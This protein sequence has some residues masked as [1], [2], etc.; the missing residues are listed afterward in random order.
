[1]LDNPDEIYHLDVAENYK[2]LLY[3]VGALAYD[4]YNDGMWI[5]TNDGLFFYDFQTRTLLLPFKGCLEV[6]D[7]S[8][9][10]VISADDIYVPGT[11]DDDE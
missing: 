3:H 10:V 2:R 5:G 1:M 7:V 11:T 4:K 6:R 8:Y 9:G